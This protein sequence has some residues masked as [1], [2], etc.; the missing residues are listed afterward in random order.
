MEQPG[1]I[2]G[3]RGGEG[4]KSLWRRYNSSLIVVLLLT[5]RCALDIGGWNAWQALY[6]TS[7]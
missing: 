2:R 5:G 7:W 1:L 4:A 3:L 6:R